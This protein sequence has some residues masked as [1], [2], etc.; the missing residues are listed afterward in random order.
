MSG[1]TVEQALAALQ[2]HQ[3]KAGKEIQGLQQVADQVAVLPK[4]EPEEKPKEIEE[5]ARA[6]FTKQKKEWNRRS[7]AHF[8]AGKNWI[9]CLLGGGWLVGGESTGPVKQ[10]EIV[11]AR[12]SAQKFAACTRTFLCARVCFFSFV[13]LHCVPGRAVLLP[14]LVLPCVC[15]CALCGRRIHLYSTLRVCTHPPERAGTRAPLSNSREI[16]MAQ[17]APSYG[18]SGAARCRKLVRCK[19]EQV[20]GFRP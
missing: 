20:Q 9:C 2:A 10:G 3:E 13:A 8:K 5:T 11:C 4:S 18:R 17:S 12:T 1:I 6:K 14:V 7:D 16:Q 19:F 15:V